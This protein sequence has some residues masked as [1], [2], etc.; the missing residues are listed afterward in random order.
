MQK[1]DRMIKAAIFD[2][3]DTLI[4]SLHV[5]LEADMEY[6]KSKG[7]RFDL[8]TFEKFKKMTYGQ[9]ISYVKSHFAFDETEEEISAGIMEIVMKKYE[10]EVKANDGI[11]ELLQRLLD[12]GIKMAV[13]TSNDRKLISRALR[14]TGLRRYF[15][16]V[17]TCDETG[18]GKDDA[19]VYIKVA[20]MLGVEP[21]ETLV[22]EDDREYVS[23]AKEKGFVA[24]HISDIGRFGFGK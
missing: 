4:D 11:K 1:E 9:S 23:A 5:W 7:M 15:S 14:N 18:Y 12:N 20:E 3:D 6:L 13:A 22:V 8:Q 16:F 24:I 19:G 17:A 2:A 21:S 10:T